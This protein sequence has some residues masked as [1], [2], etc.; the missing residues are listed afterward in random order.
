MRIRLSLLTNLE[1]YASGDD[2]LQ[3]LAYMLRFDANAG[4]YFYPEK[5]ASCDQKLFLNTGTTYEENVTPRDDVFVMKHG[6]VI[7]ETAADYSD[8]RCK[9]ERSENAFKSTLS[10]GS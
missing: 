10:I 7:P 4:Y 6:L 8:F 9:M 1:G 5:G 2:Y 3:L